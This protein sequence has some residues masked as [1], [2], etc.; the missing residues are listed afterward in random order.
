[1]ALSR[2]HVTHSA[3]TRTKGYES[4]LSGAS[5]HPCG[6]TPPHPSSPLSARKASPRLRRAMV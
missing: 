4:D 1:M 5:A 6:I 2:L 3:A